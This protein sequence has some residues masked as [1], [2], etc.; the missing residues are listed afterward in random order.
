MCEDS[1]THQKESTKEGNRTRNNEATQAWR[2]QIQKPFKENPWRSQKQKRQNEASRQLIPTGVARLY[3]ACL[4]LF[5]SQSHSSS[6]ILQSW[7]WKGKSKEVER[8]WRMSPVSDTKQHTSAIN[9]KGGKARDWGGNWSRHTCNAIKVGPRGTQCVDELLI[10]LLIDG[11]PISNLKQNADLISEMMQI[12][13][14]AE[15]ILK[16]I[17]KLMVTLW[18]EIL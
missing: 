16:H 10:C 12:K 13:N 5:R 9:Y 6:K 18:E 7:K 8:H 17:G 2:C 1:G 4:E 11:A 3:P 14:L 15:S